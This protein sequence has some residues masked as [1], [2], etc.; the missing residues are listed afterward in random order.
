LFDHYNSSSTFGA[1]RAGAGILECR[2]SVAS[3]IVS[4]SPCI[5]AE[6]LHAGKA[7]RQRPDEALRLAAELWARSRQQG[8]P[9]AETGALDIDVLIAAQALTLA[10]SAEVIVATTNPK[11]LAQFIPAKH[12]NEIPS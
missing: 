6:G 9:T 11:H 5:G 2:D 3:R 1:N 10:R 7:C 4:W 12:W 8:R